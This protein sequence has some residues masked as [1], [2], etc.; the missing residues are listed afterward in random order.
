MGGLLALVPDLAAVAVDDVA[1]RQRRRFGADA[2]RFQFPGVERFRRHRHAR[3]DQI[4]EGHVLFGRQAEAQ[5]ADLVMIL[6]ARRQEGDGLQQRKA[7][8]AN[9]QVLVETLGLGGEIQPRLDPPAGRRHQ[10]HAE[11]V[12]ERPSRLQ[13][14]GEGVER[15]VEDLAHPAG[16]LFDDADEALARRRIHVGMLLEHFHGRPQAGERRP[17]TV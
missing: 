17:R 9:P 3:P 2:H 13:R 12:L 7:V 14:I 10:V 16:F 15:A 6:Q 4:D 1:Q 8:H 11:H 5:L